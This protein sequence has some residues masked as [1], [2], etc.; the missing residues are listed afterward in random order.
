MENNKYKVNL[1]AYEYIYRG[2]IESKVKYW[3]YGIMI[4]L[5]LIMFLPWTQNIKAKGS[6]TTLKQ[7][8]RPQEINSPIPGKIVKW[9]VKE[10]DY[11]RKGDTILQISETF[12]SNFTQNS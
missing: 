8:Q 7:E 6:I 3:F 11:V 2:K 4:F 1:R 5:V 10:G 9:W 12:H